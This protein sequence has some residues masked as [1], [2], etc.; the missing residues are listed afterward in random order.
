MGLLEETEGPHPRLL[1]L[2]Q[3]GAEAV[4]FEAAVEV[5]SGVLG[6]SVEDTLEATF[7]RFL[8]EDA[9]GVTEDAQSLQPGVA[10]R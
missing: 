1:R 6:E 8:E 7:E 9:V 2:V 10:L 4:L 3:V 5:V